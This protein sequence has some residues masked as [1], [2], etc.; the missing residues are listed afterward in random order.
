M[1]REARK[2]TVVRDNALSFRV[3]ESEVASA[4]LGPHHGAVDGV[5]RP[6]LE[7]QGARMAEQAGV[8]GA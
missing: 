7:W 5:V 4:A 3:Y 8:S 6:R 2:K 1:Q